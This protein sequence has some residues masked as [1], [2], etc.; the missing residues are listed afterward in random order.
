MLR[1]QSSVEV[2]R[3]PEVV[4]PYLVEPEKQALWSD[5]SM[6]PVTEGP[7]VTGSR[8][9][10]SFGKGPLS[11]KLGVEYTS[12]EP[13]RRVA[14]KSY[15]GP[16]D[17]QGEYLIEPTSEGGAR[18]SQKGTLTFHGLWRLLEPVVGAE[19]KSAEV[20]ELERL[21][22]AAEASAA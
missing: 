5:V 3:P 10:I 20:K 12:L 1:Y 8:I 15:S 14:W 17:W 4:F 19:I 7:V 21:K 11:A 16:I 9:E 2:S 6:R 18:L 22:A 13:N